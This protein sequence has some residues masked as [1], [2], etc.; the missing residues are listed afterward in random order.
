MITNDEE[1]PIP[2]R[3][4]GRISCHNQR[5]RRGC[6]LTIISVSGSR[7]RGTRE[8]AQSRPDTFHPIFL[9]TAHVLAP[10]TRGSRNTWGISLIH[11][12]LCNLLPN[13][14][15]FYFVRTSVVSGGGIWGR[16]STSG[17][18]L[19]LAGASASGRTI[20]PYYHHHWPPVVPIRR[21]VGVPS[22]WFQ[23]TQPLPL[24]HSVLLFPVP[25]RTPNLLSLSPLMLNPTPWKPP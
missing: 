20:L 7:P 25:I 22:H 2:K 24:N 15:S 5:D 8:R 17:S 4:E 14:N 3:R 12:P 16:V 6:N 9:R 1:M 18:L 10:R 13:S 19:V 23:S 21:E 11:V